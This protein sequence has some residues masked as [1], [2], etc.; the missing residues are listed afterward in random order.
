VKPARRK[1]TSTDVAERAERLLAGHRPGDQLTKE[2]RKE[3]GRHDF[4]WF[5]KYYMADYFSAEPA[6]FHRELAAY[7]MQ[8]Q[9]FVGAAPREHAKSTTVSFATPI[10][11]ICYQLRRF[12]VIFRDTDAVA[13]Q[14]VDD[15]RQELES[16]ERIREDFGELV[17]DRKWTGSEFVTANGVKVLGRGR[18]SSARGLRFKQYRPDL[19]IC[20]DLEDDEST[21]SRQQRDKLYRWFKR[22]V[23]N[24]ISAQGQLFVIGTILH[25]DSLLSRLLKETNVY[26]TRVWRAL[27][28]D[29]KPLWPA[30]WPASRLQAKKA[31]IGSRAF[32]TEFMNDAAN[33]EEQIFAPGCFGRFSDDDVLGHLETVAAIDPAIGLKQK[34]DDTGLVVAA[35]RNGN[36]Y[37]LRVRLKKMKIQDQ[38]NLVLSTAR[39]FPGLLKF[40]FETIAYQ[41]ALK[42]LVDETSRR[43]R[44]QIPAV[45]VEDITSDKLKRISTLVPLVEQRLIFFPSPKSSY[46]SPDVEKCIEEFESLGCSGDSHDDGPD[47]TQR[48]IALLRRGGKK[49]TVKLV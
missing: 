11:R 32:A 35:T 6:D 22:T 1:L 44:L 41:T 13:T 18:G 49:G 34:N 28:E 7:A 48:A 27:D 15:I 45:A 3:R 25:H 8:C 23:S 36:Y 21:E 43:E 19:V 29:G 37:I 5:C 46:W 14:N 24:I 33:E 42:Q 17:G 20:D 10:H 39:E 31:E 4:E 30:I 38:V 9:R 12:I 40:G 47:A 16:N 26:T 2:Q